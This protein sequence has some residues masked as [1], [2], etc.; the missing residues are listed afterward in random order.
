MNFFKIGLYTCLLLLLICCKPIDK[1]SFSKK[2]QPNIILVY[3]DDMGIGDASYTNGKTLK[4]PNIDRLAAEGKVFKQYYS[5]APVCSPSRVAITTGMYPISWNINTF[6][7]DKKF[8]EKCDQSD[9]LQ[10]K[11][12]S[13]A[14][15]LKSGGY[16]TAHFG[17]W[18]MGGGRDVDNAPSIADY[19]FDTFVSTYESPNPDLLLTSTKWIWAKSDSIKR[20]ERTGYF[21]DKTLGFLKNNPNT[22][23]FINLWPDDVHS[24]WVP[25]PESL[26]GNKKD[27]YTLPNLQPVLEAF[28]FQ[29]GRLLDGIK[30]LGVDENT[31]IIFSSDNGPSPSFNRVRTNGLRGEKNSLYEGGILMP[32]IVRW[33]GTIKG[34]KVDNN[35]VIAAIDILPT[36]CN[37][38]GIKDQSSFSFDG[39]DASVAFSSNTVFTRK[40]DLFW[41]YG[42]NKNYNYPKGENRSLQLATRFKNYKF[43]TN[44]QG[45]NVELYDLVSDPNE[46]KDIS[47]LNPELIQKLKSET[48]AWFQQTDKKYLKK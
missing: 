12:P 3:V 6:L 14:R 45:D 27:F 48:L 13:M 33:P 31:I 23:C 34:N 42:R 43:Y 28:D 20:W 16:T 36:V 10:T 7:S 11:A 32:F 4:T 2:K 30:K 38:A 47:K 26:E 37:I 15:I 19:G 29:I 39:E 8:N 35:S 41:E 44:L 1:V 24:P 40:K 18:H 9:F 17:K 46:A 21:V 22:P 25:T 5:N